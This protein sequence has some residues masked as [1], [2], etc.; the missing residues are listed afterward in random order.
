MVL[1]CPGYIWLSFLFS[2]SLRIWQPNNKKDMGNMTGAV[3]KDM[4]QELTK[5]LPV[6]CICF[7]FIDYLLK[8]TTEKPL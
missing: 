8:T 7:H 3:V 6:F 1:P 5:L 4:S 2:R